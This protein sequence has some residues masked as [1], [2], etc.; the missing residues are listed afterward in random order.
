[1]RITIRFLAWS[2]VTVS[3]SQGKLKGNTES[4]PDGIEE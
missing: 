2:L 1:V 3:E 4:S